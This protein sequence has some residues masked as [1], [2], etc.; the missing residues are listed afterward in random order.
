M[1]TYGAR[2]SLTIYAHFQ[3]SNRLIH[4]GMNVGERWPLII[5]TKSGKEEVKTS[6]PVQ[7]SLW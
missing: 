2:V 1:D 3:Q 6:S 7:S 5:A 4:V